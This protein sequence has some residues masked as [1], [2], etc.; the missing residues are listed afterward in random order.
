[1]RA[2]NGLLVSEDGSREF[3]G[4]SIDTRTIAPGDLFFAIRGERLDG[5]DFLTSALEKGASGVVAPH[6]WHESER[7]AT[8]RPGNQVV[9][10]SDATTAA[11]HARATATRRAP[12]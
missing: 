12:Q 8:R 6:G 1:M 2:A 9:I 11:L 5:A 3:G 4:V 10:N 7:R